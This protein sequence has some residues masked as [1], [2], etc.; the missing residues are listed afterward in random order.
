[1]R[2]SRREGKGNNTGGIT[3][4][5]EREREREG[6]EKDKKRKQEEKRMGGGS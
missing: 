5:R 6:G 4:E 2:E 3:G 1:M